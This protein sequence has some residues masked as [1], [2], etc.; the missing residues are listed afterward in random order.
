MDYAKAQEI[1]AQRES[2]REANKLR[3]EL[4]LPRMPIPK[5]TK[6]TKKIKRDPDTS[7]TDE[8]AEMTTDEE[9]YFVM[10][11]KVKEKFTYEGRK[12]Q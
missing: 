2:V 4:G 6:P 11:G 1:E 7:A 10:S 5:K 9:H 3:R 12:Y 8:D